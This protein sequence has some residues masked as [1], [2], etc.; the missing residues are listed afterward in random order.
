MSSLSCVDPRSRW[1]GDCREHAMLSSEVRAIV[2]R[3]VATHF[4]TFTCAGV[5]S[6]LCLQSQLHTN[7]K[8]CVNLSFTYKKNL[9]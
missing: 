4:V 8:T 1:I 2:S 7:E 6:S 3:R 9:I 5:V